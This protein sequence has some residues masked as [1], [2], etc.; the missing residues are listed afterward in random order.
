MRNAVL[1]LMV[2]AGFLVP[3]SAP[4]DFN[5]EG[6]QTGSGL[7]TL[8]ETDGCLEQGYC[9]GYMIGAAD[10]QAVLDPWLPDQLRTCSAGKMTQREVR[11]AVIE[12]L[13][14]NPDQSNF[15]GARIVFFAIHEA[16][17]CRSD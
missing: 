8:C 3:A 10:M 5:A 9:L 17:P 15:L 13:E 6:F 2:L 16:F 1:T 7:L 14:E 12:Y 11:S 4:T